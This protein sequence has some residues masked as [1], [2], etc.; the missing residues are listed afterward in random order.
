MSVY[1]NF[2]NSALRT[3]GGQPPK[4]SFV[5]QAFTGASLL[6]DGVFG[7]TTDTQAGFA[8]GVHPG[9]VAAA[10]VIMN[11]GDDILTGNVLSGKLSMFAAAKQVKTRAALV[12]SYRDAS[13]VDRAALGVVVGADVIFDEV[14]V[15]ALDPTA[16]MPAVTPTFT[17]VAT[18]ITATETSARKPNGNGNGVR[19]RIRPVAPPVIVNVT[20]H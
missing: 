16:N 13:L 4:R 10:T 18:P 9:Y 14:V 5:T 20:A 2:V 6:R 11:A 19:P 8:C 1:R 15:P 17:A 7:I 12:S 3:R